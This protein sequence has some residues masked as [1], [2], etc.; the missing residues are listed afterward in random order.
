MTAGK[1]HHTTWSY[2]NGT[3]RYINMY[4]SSCYCQEPSSTLR[5]FSHYMPQKTNSFKLLESV[6]ICWWTI[7]ILQVMTVG[8]VSHCK[9]FVWEELSLI[10]NILGHADSNAWEITS[11]QIG[12][13]NGI[14]CTRQQISG[15]WPLDSSAQQ[16]HTSMAKNIQKIQRTLTIYL[17]STCIFLLSVKICSVGYKWTVFGNTFKWNFLWVA[18]DSCNL[19]HEEK[20]KFLQCP[21][22][23]TGFHQIKNK[24]TLNL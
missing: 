19:I 13:N 23:K 17:V 18:F 14:P 3:F 16:I 20:Q 24:I 10:A 12:H 22:L 7:S 4:S 9:V 2:M 15:A 11:N 6:G 1:K 5:E 21:M 8:E